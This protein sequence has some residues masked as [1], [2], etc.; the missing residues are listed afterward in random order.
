MQV[1]VRLAASVLV[2][3]SCFVV[4]VST[5]GAGGGV[6]VQPPV[7]PPPNLFPSWLS[8]GTSARYEPV[9]YQ[10]P[11]ISTP[12]QVA[13]GPYS[14][15]SPTHGSFVS[16]KSSGL[17]GAL[18][19]RLTSSTNGRFGG[20]NLVASPCTA[21]PGIFCSVPYPS[22]VTP[23]EIATAQ[24]NA[25]VSLQAFWDYFAGLGWYGIDGLGTPAKIE[26]G[27]IT[28]YLSNGWNPSTFST[29]YCPHNQ[30]HLDHHVHELVH[31][32]VQ[33]TADF[34]YNNSGSGG[35]VARVFNEAY[36]D[37]FAEMV[38]FDAA[39]PD[40]STLA[41]S[42]GDYIVITGKN[43]PGVSGGFADPPRDCHLD[44]LTVGPSAPY[45]DG[46][47]IRH[48]MYLLAEGTDPPPPLPHSNVCQGPTS[49]PGIGRTKTA[50][51][52]L[53]ALVNCDWRA[54]GLVLDYCDIRRCTIKA[55]SCPHR[56]SVI[57]VWNAVQLTSRAC[58]VWDSQCPPAG[59]P[60][61]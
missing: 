46:G 54:D 33:A 3:A 5:A 57:R 40:T 61:E 37:F 16:C 36:A 50:E 38:E 41:G 58:G 12:G 44:P 26:F 27:E 31:G 11:W 6:V 52:F 35:P 60:T 1:I 20:T 23:E 53:S 43:D 51:I 48:A 9:T 4:G 22:V 19:Q 24:A 59:D 55:A 28:T 14:L 10:V 29:H 30:L 49:L 17:F 2:V 32:I 15:K 7:S 56:D 47:P 42:A 18:P 8:A 34:T 45:V 25:Y 39:L 13:G 21:A